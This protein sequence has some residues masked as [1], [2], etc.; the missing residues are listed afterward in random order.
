[1]HSRILAV[2]AAI[3]VSLCS[4]PAM[5]GG[6]PWL[7]LPVAGVNSDNADQC[8]QLVVKALG[9][10]IWHDPQRAS[11]VMLQEDQNQHYLVLYLRHNVR[12]S[13]I[14]KIF[15]G[16]EFTIP[17]EKL[18]LFGHVVLEIECDDDAQGELLE[19][20][21][22]LQHVSV[23]ESERDSKLL[24]VTVDMPYPEIVEQAGGDHVGWDRFVRMDYSS[25][26]KTRNEPPASVDMLP[27]YGGFES[28]ISDHQG[29]LRTVCWSVEHAC[30]PLGAVVAHGKQ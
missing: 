21:K 6:P 4:L 7:C 3:G 29:S 25:D 23:A 9:E 27:T 19:S 20:L 28:V 8:A 30:R 22:Q 1:M 14:E 13:D 16:T 12:L 26:Q 2:A 18:H 17:R 11:A 15:E 24:R 5:A 10:K